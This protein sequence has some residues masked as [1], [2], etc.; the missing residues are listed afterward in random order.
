MEELRCYLNRHKEVSGIFIVVGFYL[1]SSLFIY[2][3][4]V[5]IF[6]HN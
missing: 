1:G 4:L 6:R 5:Q 3:G 2:V